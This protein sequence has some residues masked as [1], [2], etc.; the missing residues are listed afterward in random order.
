MPSS[1]FWGMQHLN[2]NVMCAVRTMKTSN[3]PLFGE[4]CEVCVI[5]LDQFFNNH[6]ELVLFNLKMRIE[7]VKMIDRKCCNYTQEELASLQLRGATKDGAAKLFRHWF[8]GLGLK[9]GKKLVPIGHQLH[10]DRAALGDWLGQIEFEE[11]FSDQQ[12]DIENIANFVNDNH[13]VRAEPVPYAK[14]TLTWI[15]SVHKVKKFEKSCLEE[16]RQI[17]AVYQKMVMLHLQPTLGILPQM[18][19]EAQSEEAP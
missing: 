8:D 1:T 13:D 17:A 9:Y 3:D 16:A 4:L 7:N 5:P 14:Q 11:M 19:G 6:Q 18:A 10:R 12:R 15:G 2:G